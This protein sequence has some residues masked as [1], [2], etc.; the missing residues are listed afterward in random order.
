MIFGAVVRS[1]E[2]WNTALGRF[3]EHE[4]VLPLEDSRAMERVGRAWTGV[5]KDAPA[6]RIHAAP[7]EIT[8]RF[9]ACLR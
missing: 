8:R 5:D 6:P 7:E 3:A 1:S 9:S 4:V 2:D